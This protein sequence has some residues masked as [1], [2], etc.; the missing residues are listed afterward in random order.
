MLYSDDKQLE[1][2]PV[3]AN[4]FMNR[5][6]DLSGTNGYDVEIGVQPLSFLNDQLAN[7]GSARWL[8]LCC[9]TGARFF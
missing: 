9:G 1:Q 7:N 6:R 8:D 5:E 2:S 3:V 4:C